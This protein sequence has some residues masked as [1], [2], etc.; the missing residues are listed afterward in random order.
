VLGYIRRDLWKDEKKAVG[1][2]DM[3]VGKSQSSLS[4]RQTS[5]VY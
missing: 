4:E 1:I 2:L 3:D 5:S